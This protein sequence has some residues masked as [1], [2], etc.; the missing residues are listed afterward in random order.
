MELPYEWQ[1]IAD[2]LELKG[3]DR[4]LLSIHFDGIASLYNELKSVDSGMTTA[5]LKI[6]DK[7]RSSKVRLYQGKL[8]YVKSNGKALKPRLHIRSKNDTK[9]R[10]SYIAYSH[11]YMHRLTAMTVY[12]ELSKSL[13]GLVIHH[14]LMDETAT[15][16]G[17][18]LPYLV[19]L[20][21]EEHTRLHKL[22]N[23]IIDYVRDYISGQINLFDMID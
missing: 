11:Y 19:V 16:Q 18:S 23:M 13:D 12:N 6:T 1:V 22:L 20:D 15:I 14:R 3:Y 8:E 5:W 4:T 10:N 21:D 9:H 2:K 7:P 17:N